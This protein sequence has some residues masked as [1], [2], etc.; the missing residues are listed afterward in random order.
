M[1]IKYGVRYSAIR[2]SLV[3]PFW[4]DEEN[5]NSNI[6]I[7]EKCEEFNGEH[8]MSISPDGLTFI[9][10][11]SFDSEQDRKQ[12][13]D[14]FVGLSKVEPSNPAFSDKKSHNEKYGLIEETTF[15]EEDA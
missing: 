7:I 6:R 15:F 4:S 9:F 14:S 1:S 2:K 13:V 3:T 10:E 5:N 8:R 12:F 11:C